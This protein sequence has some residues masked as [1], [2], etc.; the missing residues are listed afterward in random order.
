MSIPNFDSFFRRATAAEANP[1]ATRSCGYQ[2]RNLAC[3]IHAEVLA[4]SELRDR[5]RATAAT[6][7]ARYAAPRS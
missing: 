1:M 4:P 7:H 3:G 5:L 2:R 6:L